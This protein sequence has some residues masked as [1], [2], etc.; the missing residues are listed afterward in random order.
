MALPERDTAFLNESGYDWELMSDAGGALFLIIRGFDVAAGGFTPAVTD[1]MIRI[2]QQYPI[3]AL[4]MWY[5]DPPIR[6]ASN[7]QFA[8]A[9]EIREPHAGRTWQR[10]SRHL[11]GRWRPG[12]DCLRSF[13]ALIRKELQG[14]GRK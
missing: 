1:L 8:Q 5:C 14:A 9:T 10:F 3:T 2:P 12:T 11:N 4:D 6:L 13:F 7:G